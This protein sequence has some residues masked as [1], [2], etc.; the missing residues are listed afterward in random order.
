M[1][2]ISLAIR[3]GDRVTTREVTAYVA[4]P[5]SVLAVHRETIREDYR[6]RTQ[7][8]RWVVTHR[9]SGFSAI[10]GI[11]T[12]GA[13]LAAAASLATHPAW[14][15]TDSDGICS[16]ANA[17]SALGESVASLRDSMRASGE[18]SKPAG[19]YAR[20]S[21]PKRKV[22]ANPSRIP[23]SWHSSLT[24]QRVEA[25]ARE[26]MFGTGN[27]GFCLACGEDASGCEP[28]ARHYECECCGEA[29]VFGAE[30]L[31]MRLA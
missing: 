3:C 13:A 26:S 8:D 9:A 6:G 18:M 31:L 19:G 27:P 2:K 14:L 16:D 25:G 29:R 1:Q 15:R 21:R 4:A 7:G 22:A 11:R 17:W 24:P 5:D 30:E 10:S 23:A 20:R 28:D 12:R